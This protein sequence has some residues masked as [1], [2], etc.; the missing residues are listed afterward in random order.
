M[1]HLSLVPPEKFEGAQRVNLLDV[2]EEE[3]GLSYLTP[4]PDMA[5]DIILYAVL[6]EDGDELLRWATEGY[7]DFGRQVVAIVWPRIEESRA[8]VLGA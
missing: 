6:S 5:L 3:L 4:F 1:S 8:L 7:F 2:V